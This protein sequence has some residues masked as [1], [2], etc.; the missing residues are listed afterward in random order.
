ML[1][2]RVVVVTLF[3]VFFPFFRSNAAATLESPLSSKYSLDQ[4]H[5]HHQNAQDAQKTPAS[6]SSGTNTN[7]FSD[8]SSPIIMIKYGSRKGFWGFKLV[9]KRT[10]N[11]LWEHFNGPSKSQVSENHS[12]LLLFFFLWQ[13]NCTE[14]FF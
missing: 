5:H 6:T 7:S 3:F 13:F 2:N 12:F 9:L 4:E 14:W 10:K 11:N 1:S 8:A